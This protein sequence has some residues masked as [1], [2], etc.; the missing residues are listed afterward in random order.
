MHFEYTLHPSI[1][2]TPRYDISV[3]RSQLTRALAIITSE[4]HDEVLAA[5]DDYFPLNNNIGMFPS[6]YTVRNN[7][8]EFKLKNG[9]HSQFLKSSRK[10]LA[11]QVIVSSLGLPF[12]SR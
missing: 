12:V 2:V 11:E 4:V 1:T 6:R 5:F 10:S 9:S 7:E 8:A 3:V